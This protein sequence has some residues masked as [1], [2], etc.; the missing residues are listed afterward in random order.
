MKVHM[1]MWWE[2]MPKRGHSD[3]PTRIT[4]KVLE[5]LSNEDDHALD[6][7]SYPYVGLEWRVWHVITF[8]QD[9]PLNERGNISVMFKLLWLHFILF[10]LKANEIS[11]K[12]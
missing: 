11:S 5:M 10:I 12:Y 7:V 1:Y 2:T 4:P 8:T 6:I 9:E 3:F